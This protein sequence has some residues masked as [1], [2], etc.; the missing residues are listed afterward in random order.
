MG[1][2][3]ENGVDS[4]NFYRTHLGKETLQSIFFSPAYRYTIFKNDR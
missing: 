2:E 1:K 4:A 3:T